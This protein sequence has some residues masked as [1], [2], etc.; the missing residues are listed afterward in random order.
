[1]IVTVNLMMKS[2]AALTCYWETEKNTYP[3]IIEEFDP[4]R[5]CDQ[6]LQN[7]FLKDKNGN[8]LTRVNMNEVAV[9]EVFTE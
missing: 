1:M 7:G 9:I 6:I 4:P 2:G 5:P 3:E 8:G